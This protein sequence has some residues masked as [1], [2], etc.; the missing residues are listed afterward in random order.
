MPGPEVKEWPVPE[1]LAG[2]RLDVAAAR[3]TGLTRSRVRRLIEEG[4]VLVNGRVAKAGRRVRGGERV[5]VAVPPPE[6]AAAVPEPLPLDVV[7]EDDDLL[8]VNKPRGMVVHPGAGHARGTLVNALLHHCRGTL[9]G[10]GGVMRPGIVHR[11]DRDTSGLLV[12]AKNDEAHQ[13]LARQIKARTV[14]RR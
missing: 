6:P 1:E 2:E 8:V 13:A 9:S 14:T 3:L 11:L 10:I 7:Y 5:T 12:V 4:L